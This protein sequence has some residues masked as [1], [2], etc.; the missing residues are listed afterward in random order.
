MTLVDDK[1]NNVSW[2]YPTKK[3]DFLDALSTS[4]LE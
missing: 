2:P 4:T 1:N 3:I